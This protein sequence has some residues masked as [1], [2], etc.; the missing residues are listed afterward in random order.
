MRLVSFENG[1]AGIQI[2][3]QLLDIS[4]LAEV[5]ED[6]ALCPTTVQAVIEAGVTAVDALRQVSSRVHS[7]AT[8]RES[9]IKVGALCAA[10]DRRL[11]S[12]LPVPGMILAA[13]MNYC[14]HLDEMDGDR[15]E[16]PYAFVK[17]SSS[18]I[19]SGAEVHLPNGRDTMVDWEAELAVVIGKPCHRVEPCD[20]LEYVFGYMAANDVS[21]RD[22]VAEVFSEPGVMEPI[23]RWGRNLLGKQFPTFCPLGPVLVTSDEIPDPGVL[24]IQCRVNGVTMQHSN[25]RSMIFS[26]AKLISYFSQYYRLMPGDVLLTGTMAGVGFGRTPPLFLKSGDRMEVEISGI[27]V[28]ENPVVTG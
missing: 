25:T 15:P 10:T 22:W 4:V 1:S 27:G 26:P 11:G 23:N 6:V 24:E 7:D 14:D 17:A 20:A 8:L 2:G 12:P 5:D 9:L 13:G 16:Y 18:V 19:G 3:D 21:A 28:L